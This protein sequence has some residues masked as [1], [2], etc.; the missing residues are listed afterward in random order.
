MTHFKNPRPQTNTNTP[1]PKRPVFF[2]GVTF[3]LDGFNFDLEKNFFFRR[4]YGASRIWSPAGWPIALVRPVILRFEFQISE[5]R[6]FLRSLLILFFFFGKID[7]KNNCRFGEIM[8]S[9]NMWIW[10][11]FWESEATENTW[12]VILGRFW[13]IYFFLQFVVLGRFLGIRSDLKCLSKCHFG[14]ILAD[15]F[16]PTICCFGQIFGNQY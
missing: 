7:Q 3:F 13:P 8:A 4:Y 16:F 14:E 5:F 2:G 11:D 1:P 10:G 15:I 6:V 9:A 12:N